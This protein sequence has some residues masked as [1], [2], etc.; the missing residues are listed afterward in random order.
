MGIIRLKLPNTSFLFGLAMEGERDYKQHMDVG[1]EGPA[2]KPCNN[3][4]ALGE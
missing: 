3:N 4:V 1:C 2:S